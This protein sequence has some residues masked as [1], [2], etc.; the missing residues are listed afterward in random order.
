M[1][2][3]LIELKDFSGELQPLN[4]MYKK[5]VLK[6]LSTCLYELVFFDSSDEAGIISVIRKKT[7]IFVKLSCFKNYK[8]LLLVVPVTQIA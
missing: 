2:I 6:V 5:R 8:F 7:A 1:K 4:T 3:V